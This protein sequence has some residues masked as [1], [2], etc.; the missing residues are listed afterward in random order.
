MQQKITENISEAP[1]G[2]WAVCT[3]CTV[4]TECAQ[5]C[6][7]CTV[8]TGG[9]NA[10]ALADRLSMGVGPAGLLRF[11]I[12]RLWLGPFTELEMLEILLD[13]AEVLEI[14]S[15]SMPQQAVCQVLPVPQPTEA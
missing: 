7:V 12:Y 13:M 15:Q 10:D 9:G 3:E 11:G 14:F 1:G 8:C 5:V 6:T 4:C 2:P